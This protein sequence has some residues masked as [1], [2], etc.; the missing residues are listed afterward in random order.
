MLHQPDARLSADRGRRARFA[1]SAWGPGRNL[2]D[3]PRKGP[4]REHPGFS[5][6]LEVPVLRPRT[7]DNSHSDI[8]VVLERLPIGDQ[9]KLVEARRIGGG[10]SEVM[11]ENA[12]AA[13]LEL[14]REEK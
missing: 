8:G 6:R 13:P 5:C 14:L 12:I 3:L 9:L 7:A 10:R 11:N 1:A 4:W 2:S